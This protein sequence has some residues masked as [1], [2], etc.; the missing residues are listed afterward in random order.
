MNFRNR[1][2]VKT[3]ETVTLFF[4]LVRLALQKGPV[5]PSGRQSEWLSVVLDEQE[6]KGC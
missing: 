2:N 5:S 4:Q 1:V 6:K 3:T